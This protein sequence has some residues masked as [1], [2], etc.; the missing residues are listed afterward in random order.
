MR[1]FYVNYH[2]GYEPFDLDEAA[3]LELT[4]TNVLYDIEGEGQER[5]MDITLPA[6]KHNETLLEYHSD[7]WA[8]GTTP[9]HKIKAA[10]SEGSLWLEGNLAVIDYNY[11]DKAYDVCFTFGIPSIFKELAALGKMREWIITDQFTVVDNLHLGEGGIF[12]KVPFDNNLPSNIEN[13]LP[14]I[15]ICDFIEKCLSPALAAKTGVSIRTSSIPPPPFP[16]V[17]IYFISQNL[18]YLPNELTFFKDVGT[19][20]V[21]KHGLP[22]NPPLLTTTYYMY[23]YDDGT[24]GGTSYVFIDDSHYV[25]GEEMFY[26]A[27]ERVQY[28]NNEYYSPDVRGKRG[29]MAFLR[30]T[31]DVDIIFPD[32]FPD[33][34]FMKRHWTD[35]PDETSHDWHT[36]FYGG[37]GFVFPSGEVFGEPLAGRTVSLQA[38]QAFTFTTQYEWEDTRES[39]GG[40]ITWRDGAPGYVNG[41]TWSGFYEGDKY[42]VT[43]VVKCSTTIKCEAVPHE[44]GRLLIAKNICTLQACLPDL[45]VVSFLKEV[46]ALHGC[47]LY[48]DAGAKQLQFLDT[49][50]FYPNNS[51]I[52][53]SE[54]VVERVGLERTFGDYVQKNYISFKDGVQKNLYFV[55]NESL[56]EEQE[57]LSMCAGTGERGVDVNITIYPDTYTITNLQITYKND[58]YES[59]GPVYAMERRITN[60]GQRLVYLFGSNPQSPVI[61][62]RDPDCSMPANTKIK[63]LCDVSTRLEV[64]VVMSAE[65]FCK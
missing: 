53:L 56:E 41:L 6:T 48:Y 38:G 14:C 17:P 11:E 39:L 61:V 35:L 59:Y 65:D 64:Q 40:P 60:S 51:D 9:R 62:S 4:K 32:D 42:N 47:V 25:S 44:Q 33:D 28:P 26:L 8:K 10:L 16:Q 37:R 57:L 58:D 18:V 27:Y 1:L 5:T 52:D 21:Y 30:A 15:N 20:K 19:F 63:T 22:P 54:R 50:F 24:P 13:V 29:E 7:V 43:F 23:P 36:Y 2:G 34:V 55:E 49:S 31:K 45:D 12:Q 3:S 46:A